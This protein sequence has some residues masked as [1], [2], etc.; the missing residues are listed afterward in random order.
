MSIFERENLCYEISEGFNDHEITSN[1]VMCEQET[2]RVVAVFYNDYDLEDVISQINDKEEPIADI[3]TQ[4]LKAIAKSAE[5]VSN[6][7]WEYINEDTAREDLRL[8]ILD[9][10]GYINTKE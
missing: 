1:N 2:G 4:K 9:Y 3:E 10:N 7:Y 5:I 8:A 6:G